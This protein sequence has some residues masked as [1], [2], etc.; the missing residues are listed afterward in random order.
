MGDLINGTGNPLK[1]EIYFN[2]MLEVLKNFKVYNVIG[3]HDAFSLPKERIVPE[4]CDIGSVYSFYI[5][6]TK[7]IVLDANFYDNGEP[8]NLTNHEWMNSIIPLSQIKWLE[9]EL[10]DCTSAIIFCHQNLVNKKNQKFGLS[11]DRDPHCVINAFEVRNIIEKYGNVK[12]VIQGHYH[13]GGEIK[14]NGVTY[15]TLPALCEQ[16]NAPYC[17]MTLNESEL[18]VESCYLL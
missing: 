15:F 16:D 4:L 6:S 18:L 3:N 1:D 5:D 7:F 14:I 2:A 17:I 11:G 13:P 9:K 10:K 12:Y 8:Y